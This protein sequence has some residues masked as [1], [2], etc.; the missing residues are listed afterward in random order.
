[1]MKEPDSKKAVIALI[2]KE[3]LPSSLIRYSQAESI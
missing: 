3:L 1:M 2:T